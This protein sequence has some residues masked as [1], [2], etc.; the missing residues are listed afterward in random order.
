M[1]GAAER[2]NGSASELAEGTV[3]QVEHATAI[4]SN[5]DDLAATAQAIESQSAAATTAMQRIAELSSGS[6]ATIRT[7]AGQ[8]QEVAQT[9]GRTA[10]QVRIL[11]DRANAIESIVSTI[12]E[13]S[14]QTN[15][16]ALNAAIEAARAGEV[17]RGFAVVADEVRLLADRTSKSTGSASTM[18]AEVRHAAS[19]I[20]TTVDAG[21]RRVDETVRH[22][23][24]AEEAIERVKACAA[25]A[26]LQV[27][28]ISDA[29]HAQRVST[30]NISGAI[31]QMVAETEQSCTAA[32]NLAE[33]SRNINA[34]AK[35]L[36]ADAD[37]FKLAE[38]RGKE[39]V[40]LF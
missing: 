24:Q 9:V 15:L 5:S 2:L 20:A 36:C 39:A 32:R 1:L 28:K 21:V 19:E 4:A 17:G 14:D 31:A 30:N 23:K 22:A 16:L 12:R 40:E 7:V 26:C 29:M 6:N 35:G 13:I 18:V 38:N 25:D 34:I 33:V 11:N 37:F 10:E 8:I 3:S 27:S